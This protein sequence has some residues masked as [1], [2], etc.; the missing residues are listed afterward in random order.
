MIVSIYMGDSNVLFSYF[1]AGEW[2]MNG[3]STIEH[4]TALHFKVE[5]C[6]DQGHL[7]TDLKLGLIYHK[8]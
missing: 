6:H 8:G 1:S 2:C 3:V 7:I 5:C 4:F